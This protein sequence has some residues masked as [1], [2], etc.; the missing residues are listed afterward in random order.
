MNDMD[1]IARRVQLVE[2]K[3][4]LLRRS[5]EETKR[6]LGERLDRIEKAMALAREAETV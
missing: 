6:K 1:A 5:D 4:A 3:L 2:E